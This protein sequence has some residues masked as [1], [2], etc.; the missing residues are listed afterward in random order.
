[1]RSTQGPLSARRTTGLSLQAKTQKKA[2]LRN[3]PTQETVQGREMLSHVDKRQ[4]VRG[5]ISGYHKCFDG[6]GKLLLFIE[7]YVYFS[8]FISFFSNPAGC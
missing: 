2:I 1:M 6:Y 7:K 5:G 4:K 3:M 8:L